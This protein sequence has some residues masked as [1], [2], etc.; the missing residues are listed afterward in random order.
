MKT[1]TW[2]ST[3]PQLAAIGLGCLQMSGMPMPPAA[4]DEIESVATIQAAPDAG[5][6]F[7]NTGDFYGAGHNETL[8]GRDIELTASDIALLNKAFAAGTVA[9][10]FESPPPA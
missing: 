2:G 7:L 6:R 1:T 4:P 9:R 5:V 3:G 10:R 8:I